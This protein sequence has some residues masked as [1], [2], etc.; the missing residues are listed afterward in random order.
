MLP[1]VAAE[2][3]AQSLPAWWDHSPASKVGRTL[4]E[5]RALQRERERVS[6]GEGA[7]RSPADASL[8]QSLA[9]LGA[10]SQGGQDV[11]EEDGIARTEELL[12]VGGGGQS[13]HRL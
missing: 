3:S 12:L 2:I 9:F 8:G 7:V 6:G 13:L 1:T 10:T 4:G 11:P 5:T